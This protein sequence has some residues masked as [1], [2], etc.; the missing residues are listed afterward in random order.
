MVTLKDIARECNVSAT[1][2][3]N[4]LSGKS[5]VG[6]QTRQKVLET[7]RLRGYQPNYIAQGLRTRR[8]KIIGVIAED[9]NQFS[10]PAILEGVMEVCEEM[11]YQTV[12]ENLRLYARWGDAWYQDDTGYRSV[13]EPALQSLQSI[14]VDGLLYIA[15]HARMIRNFPKP[16][17]IPMVMAYA[18]ADSPRIPSVVIDDE[19]AACQ[20]TMHLLEMGHRKIAVL[21]GRADNIH[22]QKRLKGYQKALFESGILYDPDLVFYGNW[23]KHEA[24]AQGDAIR[25]TGATAVFCMS[26]AMAGGLYQY[27][28][29]QG[30]RVGE[31][32]SVVGFDNQDLSDFVTPGL[33]TMDL[34]LKQLGNEAGRLI[35]R[36]LAEG[37]FG[38]DNRSE[39]YVACTLCRRG[40][41]KRLSLEPTE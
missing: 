21:A 23:T 5:N 26:D 28:W 37:S 38:E 12:I 3:S 22:T 6:E 30:L 20:L 10:T 35:L 33:T 4:I 39:R 36:R 14:K 7:I 8:T 16:E 19:S 27:F 31:D 15:G 32:L 13:L 24:H 11:G 40:S 41:V 17:D 9:I 2:V 29:E 34:N 18:Y 1:T 25:G